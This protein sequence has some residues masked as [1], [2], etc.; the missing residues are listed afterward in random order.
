MYEKC[1]QDTNGKSIGA[2]D[3]QYF[4]INLKRLENGDSCQRTTKED[5]GVALGTEDVLRRRRVSPA[6]QSS[7]LQMITDMLKIRYQL[8]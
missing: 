8:I 7:T 3:R 2:F 5:V 6:H 4:L 1:Q